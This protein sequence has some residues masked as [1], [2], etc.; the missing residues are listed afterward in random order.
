MGKSYTIQSPPT[1]FTSLA[2]IEATEA[3][4]EATAAAYAAQQQTQYEFM[5]VLSDI[6]TA[7]N[8]TLTTVPSV[9]ETEEIDWTAEI[10]A[11]EAEAYDEII[12][13]S[14]EGPSGGTV[15]TSPLLWETEASVVSPLLGGS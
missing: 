13:L 5:Q 9:T 14:P 4:K 6:Q 7:M 15:I 8:E 10:D 2:Q 12:G 11:M 3:L 1:D